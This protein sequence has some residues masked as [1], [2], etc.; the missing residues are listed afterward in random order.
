MMGV[1][2]RLVSLYTHIYTL[3]NT[4]ISPTHY[5]HFKCY[6]FNKIV[7]ISFSKIH[8]DFLFHCSRY[9]TPLFCYKMSTHTGCSIPRYFKNIIRKTSTHST[10]I[11]WNYGQSIGLYVCIVVVKLCT[12]SMTVFQFLDTNT[13]LLHWGLAFLCPLGGVSEVFGFCYC[14]KLIWCLDASS[15]LVRRP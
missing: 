4:C 6:H 3:T 12:F 10:R 15:L 13:Y 7:R 5:K 14:K 11:T 1:F 8:L 2:H 9:L